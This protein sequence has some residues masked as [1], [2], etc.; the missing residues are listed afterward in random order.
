MADYI[1]NATAMARVRA[2]PTTD[3][4]IV[5]RLAHLSRVSGRDVGGWLEMDLGV[6]GAPLLTQAST[7]MVGYVS[8]TLLKSADEH[9]PPPPAKVVHPR[10]MLG[11]HQLSDKGTAYRALERGCRAVMVFEGALEAYQLSLAYPDAIIIHRKYFTVTP[12]PWEMIAQ[13]GVNPAERGNESRAFYRGINE[14]DVGSAYDDSPQGILNRAKWDIECAQILKSAAPNARWVAGGFSHGCPDITRK[15]VCEALRIGYAQAYNDGLVWF[16]IHNYSKA[17]P[18][19]PFDYSYYG[20][21]WFE[22]RVDW[23]FTRCGFDPRVR[24][25]VSSEA[26]G[27]LG[28][29]SFR[30]HGFTGDQFDAWCAYYLGVMNAPLIVGGT[31][32]PTPVV[33]TTIFQWGN[34]YNGPG[35]WWGYNLIPEYVDKLAARWSGEYSGSRDVL[36]VGSAVP[37]YAVPEQKEFNVA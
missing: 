18:G 17:G 33:A 5:G 13:H 30:Q 29:G 22:R 34:D 4:A 3:S 35:G 14:F 23:L 6:G 7:Q 10:Q 31:E 28:G 16:D 25:C 26:G 20:P 36:H 21:E 27:E 15:D 32:Y 24:A 12:S 8:M 1:V 2:K 9:V 19:G 37:E 11:V